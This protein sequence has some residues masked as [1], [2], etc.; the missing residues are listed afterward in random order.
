MGETYVAEGDPIMGITIEGVDKDGR[1]EL[2]GEETYDTVH[3]N[4]CHRKIRKSYRVFYKDDEGNVEDVTIAR[5]GALCRACAY[6]D[7]QKGVGQ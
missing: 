7:M 3:C 5:E 2:I 1:T 4:M 6:K